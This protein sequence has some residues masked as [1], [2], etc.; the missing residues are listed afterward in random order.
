MQIGPPV[1]FPFKNKHF[2]HNS[3]CFTGYAFAG[4]AIM[5]LTHDYRIMMKDC[6]WWCLSAVHNGIQLIVDPKTARHSFPLLN[7]VTNL[8]CLVGHAFAGGA[9]LSLVHD[10]RIMS[11][12]RGWW[13]L[14]EV[15]LG[16]LFPSWILMLARQGTLYLITS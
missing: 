4:G 14:N 2:Q 12:D 15:H 6:G 1:Q 8:V 10:F 7:Y 16:L 5:T 13:S 11:S 3:C 9:V